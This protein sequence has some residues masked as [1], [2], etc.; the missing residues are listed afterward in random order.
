M[1][2]LRALGFRRDDLEASQTLS[3]LIALHRR[4][5]RLRW[6]IRFPT[7]G[8]AELTVLRVFVSTV[9]HLD[10]NKTRNNNELSPGH[11]KWLL[12]LMLVG[13]KK[14]EDLRTTHEPD[15]VLV[16]DLLVVGLEPWSIASSLQEAL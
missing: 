3:K 13:Q 12:K 11:V 14:E 10:P 2:V 1:W 8:H 7:V 15:G 16:C 6:S 5:S 4:S 9:N